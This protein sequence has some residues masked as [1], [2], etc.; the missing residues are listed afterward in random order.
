[1]TFYKIK[2]K[3]NKS[4]IKLDKEKRRRKPKKK[5]TIFQASYSTLKPQQKL[6]KV[7]VRGA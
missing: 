4:Q 7:L 6:K 1:M 2:N 5:K 3:K